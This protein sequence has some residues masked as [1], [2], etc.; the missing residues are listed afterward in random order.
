MPKVLS[1]HE[2]VQEALGGSRAASELLIRRHERRVYRVCLAMARNRE[3]AMDLTQEAL[4]RAFSK[5]DSFRGSG[6]FQG[7][8][9]RVT[10]RICLNWLRRRG[11]RPEPEELTDLNAPSR[12]AT[13]E[14][15]LARQEEGERL[16]LEM[17][18]LNDRER[19]AL[20]LRY[21]EQMPIRE[22]AAALDCTEGTAKSLLFRTITKLRQ[23]M[24]PDRDLYGPLGDT[25]CTTASDTTT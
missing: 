21:F 11:R 2:L 14:E 20:G 8:L 10:N 25:P 17:T 12:D 19:L 15:E 1:D 23:R 16:R 18:R 5:L 7:W 9:L 22:V 4:L 6:S 3:D 13:Q 24:A